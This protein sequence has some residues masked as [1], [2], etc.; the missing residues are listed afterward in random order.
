[1]AA[2]SLMIAMDLNLVYRN[3]PADADG[4]ECGANDGLTA[5]SR[6][7]PG[8]P[9]AFSAKGFRRGPWRQMP[10]GLRVQLPIFR[11]ET[12]DC[13][14]RTDRTFDG[15]LDHLR[16]TAFTRQLRR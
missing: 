10:E 4:L 1:M 9:A 14:P 8:Q 13:R 5:R 7:I 15:V 12:E 11:L 3:T 2:M 6:A 16:G